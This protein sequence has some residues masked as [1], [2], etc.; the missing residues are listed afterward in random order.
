MITGEYSKEKQ[1]ANTIPASAYLI[2]TVAVLCVLL[3]NFL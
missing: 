1:E 2:A 3:A